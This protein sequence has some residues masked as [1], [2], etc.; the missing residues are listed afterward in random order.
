MGVIS[1][2]E[3]PNYNTPST[4]P[5]QNVVTGY[6]LVDATGKLIADG[7]FTATQFLGVVGDSFVMTIS[8]LFGTNQ[9]LS[10]CW[11]DGVMQ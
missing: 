1:P 3:N 4:P 9:V 2:Q 6:F 5:V 7:T 8:L 11:V 10:Q